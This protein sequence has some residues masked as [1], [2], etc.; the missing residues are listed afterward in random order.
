MNEKLKTICLILI[1]LSIVIAS[2]FYCWSIYK[3]HIPSD[4]IE[5]YEMKYGK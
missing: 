4:I 2:G 1:T 5:K 3:E